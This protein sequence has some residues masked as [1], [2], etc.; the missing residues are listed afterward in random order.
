MDIENYEIFVNAVQSGSISMAAAENGYTQSA[1]S[2]IFK[3]L[4]KKCGF[5]L[6]HRSRDGISLT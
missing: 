5:K 3:A 6:V 4:E 1:V 2:Y